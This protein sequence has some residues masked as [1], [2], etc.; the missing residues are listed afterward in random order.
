MKL[1]DLKPGTRFQRT[2]DQSSVPTTFVFRGFD[3]WSLDDD[4]DRTQTLALV[5]VVFE[6]GT[7]SEK[8]HPTSPE[9]T[10]IEVQ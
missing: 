1:K 10:V 3:S 8:R 2:Q 4:P 6:D 5:S 7:V 9:T